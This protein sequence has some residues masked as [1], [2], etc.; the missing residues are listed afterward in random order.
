MSYEGIA[1]GGN[2]R[3]LM[4]HVSVHRRPGQYSQFGRSYV[5]DFV[6]SARVSEMKDLGNVLHIRDAVWNYKTAHS[7][8]AFFAI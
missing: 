7:F 6:S 8:P 3:H 2:H 4:R 1:G 5:V